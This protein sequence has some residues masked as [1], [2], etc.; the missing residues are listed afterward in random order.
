MENKYFFSMTFW[1]NPNII[2]ISDASS[3]SHVAYAYHMNDDLA[4]HFTQIDFLVFRR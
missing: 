3:I 1:K 2:W 4:I